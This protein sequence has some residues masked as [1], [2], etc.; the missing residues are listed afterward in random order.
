[1][2]KKDLLVTKKALN[3]DV[4]DALSFNEYSYVFNYSTDSPVGDSGS[5]LFAEFSIDD[6]IE[7][8][9]LSD[10]EKKFCHENDFTFF[11]NSWQSWGEGG[12][13]FPGEKQKKY[14][15][16]IPPFK[17]Y[18][19]W[20]G[21]YPKK[22][23]SEK[24]NL[25][26]LLEGFFVIYVRWDDIYLTFASTA[27]VKSKTP[28]PPVAF[29]A[30][31]KRRRV[32]AV[33]YSD[34]KKWKAQEKAGE[35]T[36]FFARNFFSLRDG[37]KALFAAAPEKRFEQIL[38]LN[39]GKNKILTGGWES[40]YNHYNHISQELISADLENLGKTENLIKKYFIDNQHETVFQVDDG[41]ESACG[42]WTCNEKL[43]PEGMVNL[44]NAI[45]QKGF[46]PGLWLAPFIVD[47][48]CDFC[49]RHRDW[50][51]CDKNGKPVQAGF[52]F[53]WGAF[54][55]KEQP[56]FPFAYYCYDLSKDEVINYLD[57]LMDKVI[58]EW[59]FRYLKLDF[60]FAGML[61]GKFKNGGTA[62]EWYD[63]AIKVL[64]KRKKNKNGQSV[65]YLGCGIP[66][67]TGFKDFPL[68]RIGPDTKED[69]DYLPMKRFNFAGRPGAYVS[70]KSTLGHAFWDQAVFIN[71]PDVVF[72]R[73]ENIKLSD[74]EKELVALTNYLFASQ[75]MHSDDPCHFD[76]EREEPFTKKI[77][78]LYQKFEDEEFGFLTVAKDL[79]TIF[80]RNGRYGGFININDKDVKIEKTLIT[81]YLPSEKTFCIF[82]PVV[83][84]AVESEKFFTA[85]KHSISIYEI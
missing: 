36:T 49:K 23:L 27:L 21:K 85:E 53:A 20:P 32:Y 14:I 38:P 10:E 61:N 28:L 45:V 64:T 58:N 12:E 16:V 9:T 40:W 68:S 70:L 26:N 59:G 25:K 5:S 66:F 54:G 83:E 65:T 7:E 6:L 2:E 52:N 67:E 22:N 76:Q 44:S 74:T 41:W 30:D 46:V 57:L 50:L 63:K 1:M 55:G 37:M 80:S 11:G 8:S 29:F 4:A 34:G 78:E 31:S 19:S 47:Y 15:P 72:M 51:L 60:L 33:A 84:H 24:S 73:Y 42:E 39:C 79:Y 75:I 43:F 62:Y 82:K 77:Y 35:I 81:K 13:I 3:K 69:W 56:G 71:D 48:R 18:V 17:Q